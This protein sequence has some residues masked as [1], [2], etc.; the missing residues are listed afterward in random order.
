MYGLSYSAQSRQYNK[1]Q[2]IK[3]HGEKEKKISMKKHSVPRLGL[4]GLSYKK[5]GEEQLKGRFLSENMARG[6]IWNR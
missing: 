5:R 1:H 6:N 4:G 2:H 3:R